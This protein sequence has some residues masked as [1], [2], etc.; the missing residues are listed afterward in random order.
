MLGDG[1]WSSL[2]RPVQWTVS[3]VTLCCTCLACGLQSGA[4]GCPAD[5]REGTWSAAPVPHSRRLHSAVQY[6]WSLYNL[7]K[8]CNICLGPA[9]GTRWIAG[10]R[11]KLC[12]LCLVFWLCGVII[13][14]M[15]RNIIQHSREVVEHSIQWKSDIFH[16]QVR[17]RTEV[18]QHLK[19]IVF[20]VWFAQKLYLL[21]FFSIST[22]VK[23]KLIY[24]YVC[25]SVESPN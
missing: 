16:K 1:S 20:F 13:L 2:Y 18:A 12:L 24:L 23:W 14:L 7:I 4:G 9:L 17:V 21:V 8:I 19:I 3:A 11:H 5:G 22:K 10:R 15:G 6:N 25:L